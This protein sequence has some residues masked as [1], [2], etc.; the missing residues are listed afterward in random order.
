MPEQKN[1][2]SV[3]S[4]RLTRSVDTLVRDTHNAV[5]TKK[6]PAPKSKKVQEKT[7]QF[8]DPLAQAIRTVVY[9][10]KCSECGHIM[11]YV[12]NNPPVRCSNRKGGC[13]RVFYNEGST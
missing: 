6:R 8:G 7:N 1:L 10:W 2:R 9:A 11:P 4:Q 12:G 3:I 5:M 13:G